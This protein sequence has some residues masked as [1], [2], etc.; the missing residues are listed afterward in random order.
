MNAP[1]GRLA[2][3]PTGLLHLGHARTFLLAYWHVRSRGGTLLMRMEDLD[4]P[5][6]EARFA[7]AALS[8]LEWLGLDWDGPVWQQS[9]HLTPMNSAISGLVAAGKAYP[10]VC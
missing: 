5:R 1:V 9:G 8:D 4:G 6:A 10:C 3:S 2:P 7:D